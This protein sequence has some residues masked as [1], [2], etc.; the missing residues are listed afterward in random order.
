MRDLKA[1]PVDNDLRAFL[2]DVSE[3]LSGGTPGTIGSGD[4]AFQGRNVSCGWES[5]GIL[6]FKRHRAGRRWSFRLTTEHVA[7]AVRGELIEIPMTDM[8]ALAMGESA[9]TDVALTRLM[10]ALGL[11]GGESNPSAEPEI[12]VE[13]VDPMDL[14]I[15]TNFVTLLLEQELLELVPD[16]DPTALAVHL[17]P[18]LDEHQGSA[19]KRAAKLTE[20]LV[21]QDLVEDLYA[22]DEEIESLLEA[23]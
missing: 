19:G 15:A 18:F 12:E 14:R 6:V 16:A 1:M 5:D 8:G 21:E 23:W 3:Q 2:T 20:W 17:L 7:M 13:E 9:M 11:E 10:S 22:T 4:D